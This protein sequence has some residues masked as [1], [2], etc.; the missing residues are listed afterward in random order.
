LP[1]NDFLS[2]KVA[3]NEDFYK[4]GI[5]PELLGKWYTKMLIIPPVGSNVAPES[6]EPSVKASGTS[7]GT[8]T[9]A[10][11]LWCYCLKWL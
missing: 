5:L 4:Q 7:V 1:Q 9:S 8:N 3:I 2:L 11:D 6:S 10:I